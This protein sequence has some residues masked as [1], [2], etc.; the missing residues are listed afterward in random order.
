MRS[1]HVDTYHLGPLACPNDDH[2]LTPHFTMDSL[3]QTGFWNKQILDTVSL[4]KDQGRALCSSSRAISHCSSWM[5]TPAFCA[6]ASL[7]PASS[8]TIRWLS[9]LLTPVAMVPPSLT[10]SS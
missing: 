9:D 6:F 2:R 5:G 10:M 4:R 3:A 7:E 1:R 8:P